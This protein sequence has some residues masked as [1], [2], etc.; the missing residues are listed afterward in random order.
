MQPSTRI[1]TDMTNMLITGTEP[2]QIPI[3]AK[4]QSARELMHL[5]RKDAAAQLRLNENIIDMIETN[6]FPDDM[7]PI[8]IRGYIRS[9]GKLLQVADEDIQAAL[10]PIKQK[11]A[12]P[13]PQ[14]SMPIAQKEKNSGHKYLMQG[15]SAG[16]ALVMLWMVAAWW[17]GRSTLTV[18]NQPAAVEVA[19]ANETAAP[20]GVSVQL[21]RPMNTMSTELPASKAIAANNEID[22]KDR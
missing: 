5:E 8:F 7:P 10:T 9:Y 16:I 21:A 15:L 14:L 6:S 12:A 19:Q 22:P 2:R 18:L 13:E 17:H 20:A 3:G 11:P 1:V 4:L